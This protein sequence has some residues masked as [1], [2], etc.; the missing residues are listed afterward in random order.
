MI[1]HEWHEQQALAFVLKTVPPPAADSKEEPQGESE[2]RDTQPPT[3]QARKDAGKLLN[4]VQAMAGY[5]H[6]SSNKRF[7]LPRQFFKRARPRSRR[8]GV[9]P[10]AGRSW[11]VLACIAWSGPGQLECLR[12]L[13]KPKLVHARPGNAGRP[14][15]ATLGPGGPGGPGSL[16]FGP[17]RPGSPGSPGRLVHLGC[18]DC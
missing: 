9:W 14:G 8:P 10:A 3:Q 1:K 5:N 6:Y 17:R 15:L 12:G 4:P 18:L 11:S 7:A 13:D 16:R 2:T